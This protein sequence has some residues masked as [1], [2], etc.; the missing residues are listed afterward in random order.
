[1]ICRRCGISERQSGDG[2]ILLAAAK[3][4]PKT[5][6]LPEGITKGEAYTINIAFELDQN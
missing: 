3:R 5:A 6:P 4:T 2:D 1:M